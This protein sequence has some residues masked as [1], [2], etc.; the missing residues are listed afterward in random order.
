MNA[1]LLT[2]DRADYRLTKV[3]MILRPSARRSCSSAGRST[4]RWQANPLRVTLP[5]SNL[6]PLGAADGVTVTLVGPRRGR[7]GRR[8]RSLPAPS[9]LPA[10]VV[11]F[12]DLDRPRPPLAH[13]RGAAGRPF[14]V[15][16]VH[17]LRGMRWSSSWAPRCTG[18]PVGRRRRRAQPP[19][20]P[21]EETTLFVSTTGSG[22]L[23]VV[24]A[25]VLFAMVAEAFAS[26]RRPR[27][28]PRR[29]GVRCPSRE[30]HRIVCRLD[31]L[32]ERRGMTLT[33]LS[34]AVGGHAGEPVHPEESAREGHPI[35]HAHR[36][37]RRPRVSA[38][39]SFQP[40]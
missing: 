19:A 12:C 9:P 22:P 8:N 3:L 33:A 25:A 23:V 4:T 38:R 14:T 10:V 26:R 15:D 37:V 18:S 40:S 39:R 21:G 2:F 34:E 36:V 31:E 1:R 17:C 6:E 5:A 35:R 29:G 16:A 28:R 13:R 20:S 30:P 27:G 24:G 7:G 32:L 11:T